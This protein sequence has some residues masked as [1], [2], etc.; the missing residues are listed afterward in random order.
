MSRCRYIPR[1]Q[2]LA[3]SFPFL[4]A[5]EAWLWFMRSQRARREGMRMRADE[6]QVVRP[7]DPDDIYRVA[8]G[9]AREKRIGRH[10]LKVLGAFGLLERAPDPRLREENRAWCLWDEALDLMSTVLRR[11]GIVE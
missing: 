4:D 1:K 10:H 7:C 11:K 2:S 9:L 5:E 6:S 3:P 8:M